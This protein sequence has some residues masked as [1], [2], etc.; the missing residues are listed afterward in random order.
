MLGA[1]W[2]ARVQDCLLDALRVVAAQV[3]DTAR[4]DIPVRTGALRD[5][6]RI[7]RVDDQAVRVVS[8]APQALAVESRRPFLRPAWP[9]SARE[10]LRDALR[11]ILR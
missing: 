1:G 3:L 10:S 8:E 11:E 9:P 5:S 7:E 6:L 2:L 4:T